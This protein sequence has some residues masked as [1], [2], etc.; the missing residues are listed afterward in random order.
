MQNDPT[1][2]QIYEKDTLEAFSLF[3]SHDLIAKDPFSLSE[4]EIWEGIKSRPNREWSF[5]EFVNR[6]NGYCTFVRNDGVVKK[7]AGY[8]IADYV[9]LRYLYNQE[10]SLEFLSST[11]RF[12]HQVCDFGNC[13]VV[14]DKPLM[15]VSRGIKYIITSG[16][17]IK[18]L[19][20][21]TLLDK[22]INPKNIGCDL[23]LAYSVFG[24]NIFGS[25][26]ELPKFIQISK[27]NPFFIRRMREYLLETKVF[28]LTLVNRYPTHLMFVPQN[29]GIRKLMADGTC[30]NIFNTLY[31]REMKGKV[32][33]LLRTASRSLS[34]NGRILDPGYFG[35]Y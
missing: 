7:D 35:I 27:D 18:S 17:S 29:S 21:C 9:I 2:I 12:E 8:K 13:Y 11:F 3:L 34:K 25:I 31:E 14:S 32:R 23:F 5:C 16:G 30:L 4:D 1:I 26:K 24:Y 22:L 20:G 6:M 28:L 19:G 33:E 15:E 10:K